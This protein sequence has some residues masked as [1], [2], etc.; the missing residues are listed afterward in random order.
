MREEVGESV[1]R[2][3]LGRARDELPHQPVRRR[4]VPGGGGEAAEQPLAVLAQCAHRLATAEEARRERQAQ[5][6]APHGFSW[7]SHR[8]QEARAA[9]SR[10]PLN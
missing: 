6:E 10:L 5:L 9:R 3:R 4:G 2:G 8:R 7:M 1:E